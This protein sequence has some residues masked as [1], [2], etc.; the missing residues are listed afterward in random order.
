MT[1]SPRIGGDEFAVLLPA[2]TAE[3]AY[4]TADRLVAAVSTGSVVPDIVGLHSVSAS[5]GYAML[6]DRSPPPTRR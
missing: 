1:W 6:D 3:Q 2:A 5:A 4:L